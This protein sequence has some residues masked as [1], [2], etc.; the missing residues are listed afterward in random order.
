MTGD[1]KIERDAP[2]GIVLNIEDIHGVWILLNP[3]G[4][5]RCLECNG[6]GLASEYC[7]ANG[8]KIYWQC[9]VCGG[10]GWVKDE[11]NNG[12]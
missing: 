5:V 6:S 2:D 1:R 7:V 3:P 12:E 11:V 10:S 9:P 4:S 8:V